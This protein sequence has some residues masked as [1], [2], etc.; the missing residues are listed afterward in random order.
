MKKISFI[1]L[2]TITIIFIILMILDLTK[3]DIK[4]LS[5]A[6]KNQKFN[7]ELTVEEQKTIEEKTFTKET[8][9]KFNGKDGNNSYIAV[10]GIVYDVS[11]IKEWQS[12]N[13]KNTTTGIDLTKNFINSDHM[14][15]T[16]SKLEIVGKYEK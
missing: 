3:K 9:K 8:L 6:E 5:E 12:G 1:A 16:L 2:G 14:N 10:N 15:D 4:D 7:I 13:H 11:N